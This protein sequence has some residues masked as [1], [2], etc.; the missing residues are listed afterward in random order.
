MVSASFPTLVAFGTRTGITVN[1]TDRIEGNRPYFAGVRPRLARGQDIGADLIVLTDWM[2]AECVALGYAQA[3]DA[4]VIPRAEQNLAAS[5]RDV[6]YDPGR[7]SSLPWLS[8]FTGMAWNKKAFSDLDLDPP[9]RVS[10]LWNPALRGHVEV[11]DEMRDT[12]GL[13]MSDQGV[14]V[15]AFTAEQFDSALSQLREQLSGGQIRQVRGQSYVDGLRTGDTVACFAWSGDIH[16]LN[17]ETGHEG[18]FGFTLPEAGGLRWTQDLWIPVG[19][20][21]KENAEILINYYYDP[22][23]SAAVC[24]ATG[25]VSPVEGAVGYVSSAVAEDPLIFPSGAENASVLR[26]LTAEER[27][28]FSA[29]FTQVVGG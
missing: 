21:H 27:T 11:L 29:R 17:T 25:Y 14:D 4:A 10:D 22:E 2:T 9:E 18:E 12:V 26:T 8:G 7:A 5:L 28:A 24:E 1:Y 13:I 19:S 23:V 16:Q 6:P 20:P 15:S 3:F